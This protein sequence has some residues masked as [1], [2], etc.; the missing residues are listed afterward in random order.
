MKNR[1]LILIVALGLALSQG[2][3][4]AA[5]YGEEVGFKT[6]TGSF[7]STLLGKPAPNFNLTGLSGER[8][9]LADF[10]GRYVVLEWVNFDL[11]EAR[12]H[13]DSGDV[14]ALQKRFAEQGAVWLS[15]CS[16]SPGGDGYY[17]GRE[18]RLLLASVRSRAADYLMDTDG[19]VARAYGAVP[20]SVFV[21]DP[22]GVLVNAVSID[23]I[24]S[25]APNDR[26]LLGNK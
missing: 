8:R 10:R 11:E 17:E 16:A 9:S 18:L 6:P 22:N 19:R 15:V 4:G 14:Q 12:E 1:I 5:G 2:A 23:D 24:P 21:I 7:E 3:A 26:E 13:Y 25:F 20:P